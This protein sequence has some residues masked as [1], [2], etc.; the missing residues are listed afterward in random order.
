MSCLIRI[1]T[2]CTGICFG[3]PGEKIRHAILCEMSALHNNFMYFSVKT[4]F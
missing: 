4:Y 1:Y 2:V 3:L